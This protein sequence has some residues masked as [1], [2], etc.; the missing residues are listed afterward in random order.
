MKKIDLLLVE[1]DRLSIRIFR[2]FLEVLRG[3]FR[4]IEWEAHYAQ[5][6]SEVLDLISFR[7]FDIILWDDYLPDGNTYDV[8]MP[9]AIA[10]SCA[11]VHV[12]ISS[13]PDRLNLQMEK[14]CQFSFPS[15]SP[16]DEFECFISG[17]V[18]RKFVEIL[19]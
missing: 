13:D 3:D 5:T 17:Y 4:D 9:A 12:A 11:E 18:H 19:C 6:N 14:G 7:T 2:H 10:G 1:D 16:A 15:F 8:V